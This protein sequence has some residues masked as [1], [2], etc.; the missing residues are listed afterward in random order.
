MTNTT[1]LLL[2]LMSCWH[3]LTVGSSFIV[4]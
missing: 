2:A 1:H 4:V 3:V